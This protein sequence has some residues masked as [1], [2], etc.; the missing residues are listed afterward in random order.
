MAARSDT[1]T[2]SALYPTSSREQTPRSTWT[3]ATTR[4]VAMTRGTEPPGVTTAASSPIQVS[5]GGGSS[6]SGN[7]ARAAASNRTRSRSMA[8][9]SPVPVGG[10][11]GSSSGLGLCTVP[12]LPLSAVP[13][14]KMVDIR[15][16]ASVSALPTGRMHRTPEEEHPAH[17]P[18]HEQ[19]ADCLGGRDRLADRAG[20]RRVVQRI[21]RGVRPPLPA[22]G[23]QRDLH[24]ALRSQA[25]Q[26]LLGPLRPG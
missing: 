25:A 24:Q 12:C 21:G 23:G 5:P 22:A 26:Q 1:V 6:P 9:N 11:A 18:H 15:W 10:V 4:S 16:K 2:I 19:E 17:A 14:G 13:T 8:S 20:D 7:R 3:P